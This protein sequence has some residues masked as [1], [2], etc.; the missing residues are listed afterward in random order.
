MAL[1][2]IFNMSYA[3]GIKFRIFKE[4]TVKYTDTDEPTVTVT[5][6]M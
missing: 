1:K 5:T 3:G 2:R 4:I 6:N